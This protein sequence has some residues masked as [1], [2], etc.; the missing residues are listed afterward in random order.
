MAAPSVIQTATNQGT[1]I[2]SLTTPGITTSTGSRFYIYTA[3]GSL[4]GVS[5]SKGNTYT[6]VKQQVGGTRTGNLYGCANGTGG[7][8]HTATTNYS[9]AGARDIVF[10]EV[11]TN[12]YQDIVAGAANSTQPFTLT[13]SALAD[14]AELAFIFV[15]QNNPPVAPNFTET[16]GF[17][18]LYANNSLSYDPIYVGAK[19]LSSA[20]AISPSV[21]SN[22][23][24]Q[25][26]ATIVVTLATNPVLTGSLGQWDP[27]LRILSWF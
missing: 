6:L 8:G 27:S 13:T 12:A 24:T 16:T 14:A 5:D 10:I 18:Q 25:G 19:T 15:V 1:G 20:A 21:S 11:S 9:S 3:S 22:D 2:T 26:G 7:A 4:T 17:T 23:T